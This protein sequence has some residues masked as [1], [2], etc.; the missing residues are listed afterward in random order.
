MLYSF[1]GDATA[2]SFSGNVGIGTTTPESKLSVESNQNSPYP[3]I[4]SFNWV[5][6]TTGLPHFTL[7][8]SSA[9]SANN[10]IVFQTWANN[11]LGFAKYN[12]ITF[13]AEKLLYSFVG[14][15]TAYSFS[16]NV[17]IGTNT[18]ESKL[19]VESNQNSPYPTIA[20]FNWAQLKDA[21]VG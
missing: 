7:K 10:E 13:N 1:V 2:Y 21:I 8:N 14:D 19:S 15:A 18:P 9:N 11:S 5:G 20:S 12:N 6:S 17:G 4:A 16:G 3:T